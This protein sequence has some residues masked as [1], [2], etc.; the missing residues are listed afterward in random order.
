MGLALLNPAF[1]RISWL[2]VSFLR[3]D[4]DA[5]GFGA[6]AVDLP[7]KDPR[8]SDVSASTGL[9]ATEIDGLIAIRFRLL[10]NTDGENVLSD[11]LFC[12]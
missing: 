5:D 8:H 1:R 2:R 4:V 12:C 9:R 7:N 11:G 10:R 6:V 3:A